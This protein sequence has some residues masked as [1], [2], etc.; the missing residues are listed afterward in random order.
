MPVNPPA[1]PEALP[2]TL[3]TKLEAVTTPANVVSPFALIVPPTPAT[4]N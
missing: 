1:V 4:P 3:P 2:V